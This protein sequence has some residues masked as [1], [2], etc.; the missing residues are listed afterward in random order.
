MDSQS[1]DGEVRRQQNA[2]RNKQQRFARLSPAFDLCDSKQ[3]I[4]T[5]IRD[6]ST[7]R[8]MGMFG[9]SCSSVA[10]HGTWNRGEECATHLLSRERADKE[11]SRSKR[12]RPRGF[13]LLERDNFAGP[14]SS[15]SILFVVLELCTPE[16]FCCLLERTNKQPRMIYSQGMVGCVAICVRDLHFFIVPTL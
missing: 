6:R 3:C 14:S 11:Q 13:L 16:L 10:L 2:T 9:Q 15:F 1:S 8:T 5:M 12:R 7:E 4:P